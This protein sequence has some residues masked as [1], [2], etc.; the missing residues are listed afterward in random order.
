MSVVITLQIALKKEENIF[1]V[2][3]NYCLIQPRRCSCHLL[4]GLGILSVKDERDFNLVNIICTKKVSNS[5]QN[6]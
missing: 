1:T 3:E 2:L 6:L 4:I 5:Y